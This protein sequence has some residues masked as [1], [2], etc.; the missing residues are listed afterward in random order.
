[1][2]PRN[3]KNAGNSADKEHLP[4]HYAVPVC[5]PQYRGLCIRS[6]RWEPVEARDERTTS[7]PAATPETRLPFEAICGGMNKV[8]RCWPR[9]NCREQITEMS[10]ADRPCQN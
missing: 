4:G 8:N 9:F 10:A 3:D 1:M 2:G 6:T 7:P 5:S